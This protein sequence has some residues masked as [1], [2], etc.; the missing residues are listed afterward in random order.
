MAMILLASCNS[1]YQKTQSGLMYKIVKNG[2]GPQVK[3]GEFMKLNFTMNINDSVVT[4]S[5]ESGMA[6]YAK[7][8]SVGPIYNV[9]EVLPK[10]HKGDSVVIVEIGDSLQRRGMLAPPMKHTDKRTWKLKVENLFPDMQAMQ[11]DQSADM[12]NFE[13]KQKS[14]FENYMASRKNSLQK[15]P[16]GVYVKVTDPGTGAQADS[17]KV[18]SV[19]YTGKFL[20]SEKVFESNMDD[21]NKPPYVFPLGMGRAIPGWDEGLKYFK[22]GGKGTLY[23]P[24]EMAY[25]GNPPQGMLPFQNMIFDVEIVDVKD[26]PAQPNIP[27]APPQRVTDSTGKRAR[28]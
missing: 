28:K 22:A 5:Y 10:L 8:D 20:P 15:T 16:G 18:L 19:R 9:L 26:M 17:G 1:N 14:A 12:K 7:A 11:N 21:P 3:R 13:Q 27:Q 25:G 24:N 2:S 4:S 23:I 6:V